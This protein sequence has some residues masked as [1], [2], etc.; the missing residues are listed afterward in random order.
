MLVH[1]GGAA[2]GKRHELMTKPIFNTRVLTF[3]IH[4]G[5]DGSF[6]KQ[7][8]EPPADATREELAQICGALLK[9]FK[10]NPDEVPGIEH[11]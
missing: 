7:E 3:R 4:T 1:G 10:E 6:V 11:D 9:F 2:V 5:V 8:L